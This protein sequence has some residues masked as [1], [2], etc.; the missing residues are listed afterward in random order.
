MPR[1]PA[2]LRARR[3]SQLRLSTTAHSFNYCLGV[4][5]YANQYDAQIW[6]LGRSHQLPDVHWQSKYSGCV[7]ILHWCVRLNHLAHQYAVR[8]H[9]FLW[10]GLRL[11]SVSLDDQ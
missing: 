7:E 10:L 5:G 3:R 1:S 9:D 2:V 6:V 8:K 4:G 11:P